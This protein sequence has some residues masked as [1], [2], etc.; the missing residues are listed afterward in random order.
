V[1]ASRGATDLTQVYLDQIGRHRLLTV[2][3]ERRL[4]EA[5]RAGAR[6][7]LQLRTPGVHLTPAD[8][9]RL[10][11]AVAEGEAARQT[12]IEAN[13]RLVVAVARP[14]QGRG[15]DLMDLVQEGNIGLLRAV[16]RFDGKMGN[17]FS[18]YAVWWIRQ[19]ILRAF[20]TSRSIRLPVHRET[21]RRTLA[22]V[23]EALQAELHRP[24]TI[25]ELAEASGIDL[26]RVRSDLDLPEA[27][28]SLSTDIGA[29]GLQL[30]EVL[31]D[32]RAPAPDDHVV[33]AD[34]AADLARLVGTLPPR[35]ATVVRLRFGFD[36]GE[37][38]T[39]E[40]VARVLGVTRERVRQ[41]EQRA[42]ARLRR[43]ASP[44]LLDL[45]VAA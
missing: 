9:R 8:R 28:V 6:A 17:R 27:S 2:D 24:A 12:F 42:L 38:R 20:D 13:L 18:T 32:A 15:V 19:S 26:D 7:A 44:E 4:S 30:G 35:L 5:V 10:R 33:G 29:D 37:P 31:P 14:Y 34:L 41:L 1:A 11:R 25:E 43:S 21:E 40:E 45:I 16:D 36:D 23:R 3:E 22:R 39:R